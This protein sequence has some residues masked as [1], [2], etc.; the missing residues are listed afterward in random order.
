MAAGIREDYLLDLTR[1]YHNLLS[2]TRNDGTPAQTF[3]WDSSTAAMEEN[4]T[5]HYYL[6]DEM[7]SPIR[8]SGYGSEDNMTDRNHDAAAAYL[9]YGYDE[10][11]NDLARTIGKE[12]EE[13]GIPNP[14]TAQGE[15]QPFGYTGYRY[16]TLSATYFAQA[17]E[18]DPQTGRFHAQDVIA[19]NGAVPVTLNRYTYC[20]GN[21]VGLVDLDGNEG[22]P[23]WIR[24]MIPDMRPAGTVIAEEISDTVQD[25]IA[26]SNNVVAQVMRGD[27]GIELTDAELE[28]MALHPDQ[29][30]I[31]LRDGYRATKLTEDSNRIMERINNGEIMVLVQL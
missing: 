1:P 8:V 30:V 19:G 27:I 20:L 18:Y 29:A 4:G 24:V 31:F 11:G 6:Q 15:G 13:A 2:V 23:W 12:L 22:S 5:F 17:R 9:T 14:Y 25:W 16:D 7:G 28:L 21:P 26:K 3:Y 10:F